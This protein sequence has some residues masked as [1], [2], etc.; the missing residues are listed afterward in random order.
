MN[1]LISHMRELS[2]VTQYV[3]LYSCSFT[4]HIV[5]T[6]T[7]YTQFHLVLVYS[8][9]PCVGTITEYTKYHLVHA[10]AHFP[11]VRTITRYTKYH[12]IHVYY[13]SIYMR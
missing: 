3:T 9:F 8:G 1:T 12:L 7:G 4:F 10:Y 13:H 11:Y 5:G 2:L 6:I